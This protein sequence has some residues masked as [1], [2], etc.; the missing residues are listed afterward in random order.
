MR[1]IIFYETDF[2]DKPVERFLSNLEPS[3]RAK[4][5]RSLEMLRMVPVVPAKFWY[6]LSDQKLWSIRAEYAGNIY[7]ILATTAK[8]NNGS[9]APV[10]GPKQQTFDWPMTR[11]GAGRLVDVRRTSHTGRWRGNCP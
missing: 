4:V 10:C 9:A 1:E 3:A 2:G 7:R 5:V 11:D 6:K 8:G